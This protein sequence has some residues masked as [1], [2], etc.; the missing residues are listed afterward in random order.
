MIAFSAV[1]EYLAISMYI[2]MIVPFVMVI[3]RRETP[4]NFPARC[5][6]PLRR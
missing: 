1:V 3:R 5:L 6:V 2:A 4:D